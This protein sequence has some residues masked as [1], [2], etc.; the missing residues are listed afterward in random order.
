MEE[1]LDELNNKVLK[2]DINIYQELKEKII[3]SSYHNN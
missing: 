1:S 3:I 2:K